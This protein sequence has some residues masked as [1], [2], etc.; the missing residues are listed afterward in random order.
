M[1]K[2]TVPEFEGTRPY[3]QVPFQFSLHIQKEKGGEATDLYA[4]F[5]NG[6]LSETETKEMF[7]NID[8][9]C[10]QDTYAMVLLMDVLY[11]TAK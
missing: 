4:A 8:I 7:K 11:Q 1:D 9:Y 10:G 3:Q 6:D 2:K 5:L